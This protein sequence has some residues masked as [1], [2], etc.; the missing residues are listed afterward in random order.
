MLYTPYKPFRLAHDFNTGIYNNEYVFY[1]IYYQR[2]NKDITSTNENI[3]IYKGKSLVLDGKTEVELS[4]VI[5]DYS[6]RKIYEYNGVQGYQPKNIE[7]LTDTRRSIEML[8]DIANTIIQIEFVSVDGVFLA[9][10]KLPFSIYP[11]NY[12]TPY[13]LPAIGV[14]LYGDSIIENHIPFVMTE[15]YWLSFDYAKYQ[16]I[17]Y[18]ITPLVYSEHSVVGRISNTD[19][20]GNFSTSYSLKYILEYLI[21]QVRT[22]RIYG[23]QVFDEMRGGTASQYG[24][25][26]EVIGALDPDVEDGYIYDGDVIRLGYE[27]D[28]MRPSAVGD[29]AVV[30]F[31]PDEW[32][33]AWTDS[34]GWHSVGLK[35]AWEIDNNDG[36]IIK[37]IYD[38]ERNIKNDIGRVFKIKSKHLSNEEKVEYSNIIESSY[39]ILY[40]TKTDTNYFCNVNATSVDKTKNRNERFFEIELKEAI[41][42]IR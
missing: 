8:D 41:T 37:N 2:F 1:N 22:I 32:Y 26:L 31:C 28:D 33:M 10:Y 34:K 29:L 38:E 14:K 15:N 21:G 12:E 19:D 24:G 7:T 4:P 40:N 25:E 11:N 42:T 6:Y 13:N 35:S 3:L 18:N 39:V 20:Y 27:V 36:L 30:D 5:L 17:G 23:R 9:G 16:Q